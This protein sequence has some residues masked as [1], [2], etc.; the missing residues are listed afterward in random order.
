VVLGIPFRTRHAS[1]D[2]DGLPVNVAGIEDSDGVL[3][4]D[5][6]QPNAGEVPL[7]LEAA[8]LDAQ[9]FAADFE[10]APAFTDGVGAYVA[11][12]SPAVFGIF[13]RSADSIVL[14]GV[15]SEADGQDVIAYDPPLLV[16]QLPLFVGAAFSSESTGTGTFNFNPFYFS[17][18]EYS[19]VVDAEGILTTTAGDLHVYRMRT[20]QTVTVG[21]YVVSYQQ[22]SF[23]APCVG[24]VAQIVSLEGEED[25]DFAFAS[26]IRRPAPPGGP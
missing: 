18:D 11:P 7:S 21:I 5:V 15:A 22:V 17:T 4:W 19:S 16:V 9:W 25:A 10:G 3:H 12:L 1:D 8:A 23:V 6:S 13:E 14:L 20:T 2:A 24:V 26:S